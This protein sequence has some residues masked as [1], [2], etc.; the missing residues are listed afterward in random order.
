MIPLYKPHMPELPELDTILHSGSL[1]YG[2]YSRIFE[3]RLSEFLGDEESVLV[4]NSFNMAIAVVTSLLGIR[5]GDEV[6]ASPMACLASTQPFAA[7][8]IRVRWADVDPKTGTLCPESVRNRITK[9]TKA[10]VHNHFCGYPGYIDEI[11]AIGREYG[12]P[13]IDDGIEAFGS[14]YNGK[15]LGNCG[16]DITIFSFNAVRIPNTIDG[17]AIVIRNKELI[18]KAELIRDCGIDRSIFRDELGEINPDC[19]IT[20]KG[21]SATMSNVNAYIG[22]CQMNCMEHILAAQRR[23]AEVWKQKLC[24]AEHIEIMGRPEVKPNYW[25]FGVLARNKREAILDFRNKGWYASGV[26]INNNIYSLFGKESDLK[27]VDEFYSHFMALPCGW[28]VQEEE[29]AQI[30]KDI[31]N[32]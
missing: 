5:A 19:D 12:I 20:L 24:G 7:H 29:N 2:E 3:K 18:K 13:V 25:V 28:W 11:N 21:H 22:I 9:K 27:G 32:M 30:N 10:I 23:Q 14:E 31:S 26:H 15:K 1:A 6:I 16:T 4:T 17:G 8:E